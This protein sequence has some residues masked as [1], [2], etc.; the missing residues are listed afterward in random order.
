MKGNFNSVHPEDWNC[1]LGGAYSFTIRAS[2][3]NPVVGLRLH[4]GLLSLAEV[5][6]Q[7]SS[8]ITRLAHDSYILKTQIYTWRLKKLQGYGLHSRF[9]LH[10]QNISMQYKVWTWTKWIPWLKLMLILT[11]SSS[12]KSFVS[13]CVSGFSWAGAQ[14]TDTNKLAAAAASFLLQATAAVVESSEKENGT[15]HR[16]RP[17]DLL[18]SQIAAMFSDFC[19]REFTLESHP[20]VF[21]LL[22][23]WGKKI[24]T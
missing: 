20:L 12:P 11:S 8:A 19:Y 1:N 22:S 4:I 7:P 10:N 14:F 3:I 6:K 21:F 9:F 23:G 18:G 17:T 5:T 2:A 24:C 13:W 16:P 15:Q